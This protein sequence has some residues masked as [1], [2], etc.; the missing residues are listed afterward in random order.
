M[1]NNLLAI[2]MAFT[3][4]GIRLIDESEDGVEGAG[5]GRGVRFIQRE[6]KARDPQT[7]VALKVM[8]EAIRSMWKDRKAAERCG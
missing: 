4:A 5:E 8:R 7:A 2:M 3:E 6:G 1:T